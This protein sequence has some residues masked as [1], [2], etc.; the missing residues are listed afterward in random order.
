MTKHYRLR[1]EQSSDRIVN[2]VQ[3]DVRNAFESLP[4]VVGTGGSTVTFSDAKNEWIVSSSLGTP[5]T[6]ITVTGSGG[7][8]VTLAGSQY[9]VSSSIYVPP[10]ASGLVTRGLTFS[11]QASKGITVTSGSYPY[12]AQVNDQA[13]EKVGQYFRPDVTNAIQLDAAINGNPT[14]TFTDNGGYP[15]LLVPTVTNGLNNIDSYFSPSEWSIAAVV[16]YTG[17]KAIN[18]NAK[19]CPQIVGEFESPGFSPLCPGLHCGRHAFGLS[20]YIDYLANVSDTG[21]ATIKIAQAGG[22]N[23]FIQGV[24]NIVIVTY[25]SGSQT[26]SLYVDSQPPVQTTGVDICDGLYTANNTL[27]IGVDQASSFSKFRGS[28]LEVDGWCVCLTAAEVAQQIAYLKS[29]SGL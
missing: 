10:A 12:I 11:V 24:A 18:V 20:Y 16:L 4:D 3:E 6:T 26:L 2:K 7:T 14:L 17:D 23:L 13:P 29:V 19:S 25:S 27:S 1:R 22:S 21:G 5:G 9:T 15:R 8:S 28:L